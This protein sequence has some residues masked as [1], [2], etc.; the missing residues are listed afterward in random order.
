MG[1]SLRHGSGQHERS[2]DPFILRI[3]IFN[4]WQKNGVKLMTLTQD[5]Q[6]LRN[7][8]SSKQPED[9]KALMKQ[10]I[11]DLKDSVL[12]DRTLKV[13]DLVANFTLPNAVG[14]LN[15]QNDNRLSGNFFL[16]RSM[17]SLLQPRT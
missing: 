14:K 5:L 1:E 8:L 11:A 10:A 12:G 4:R 17:V 6:Q 15:Y 2:V 9:I 3:A 13:G 7:E 16:S